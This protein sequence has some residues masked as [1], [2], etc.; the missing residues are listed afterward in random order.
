MLSPTCHAAQPKIER[1]KKAKHITSVK[2]SVLLINCHDGCEEVSGTV[3]GATEDLKKMKE[4]F[5]I[6]SLSKS[7]KSSIYFR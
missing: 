7:L 4:T 1:K 6:I 2:S 5:C 3:M